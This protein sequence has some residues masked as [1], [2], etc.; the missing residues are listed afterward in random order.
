[1]PQKWARVTKNCRSF[2]SLVLVAV[3]R[4]AV[5]FR[6]KVR[7]L[8]AHSAAF[9]VALFR[10]FSRLLRPLVGGA[11]IDHAQTAH[12]S[13]P[14]VIIGEKKIAIAQDAASDRV[15]FITEEHPAMLASAQ[16][17]LTA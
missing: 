15:G 12:W 4:F 5:V 8:L 14:F 11:M 9:E 13:S 1:M 16:R 3:V 2:Q 10:V 7:A 17:T 6:A